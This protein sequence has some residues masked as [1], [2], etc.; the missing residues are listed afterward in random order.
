MMKFGFRPSDTTGID[1]VVD[2]TL[3]VERI[4]EHSTMELYPHPVRRGEEV[5][6]SFSGG[7]DWGGRQIVSLRYEWSYGWNVSVGQRS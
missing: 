7:F 2:T 3:G 6:V 4:G 5:E 1:V